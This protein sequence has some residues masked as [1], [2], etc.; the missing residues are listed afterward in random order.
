MADAGTL[1]VV[2]T[3]IGNLGDISRRA[4]EVLGSVSKIAAEDTRH[5]KK[6]M[7][8]VGVATPLLS[9]HEFSGKAVAT[10]IIAALQ[11]GESVTL[12]FDAQA[13]NLAEGNYCNEAWVE[14]DGPESR[15]WKT[16]KIVAGSPADDVCPGDEVEITTTVDITL[17][18]D[19]PDRIRATYTIEIQK[20]PDIRFSL[21]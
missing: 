14:P 19:K 5:S 1:Y 7:Q 2:A 8:A 21:W 20:F 18:P 3:P 4:I 6:L 13:I 11:S 16:A 15:T 17:S 12:S 10:K 9:Y